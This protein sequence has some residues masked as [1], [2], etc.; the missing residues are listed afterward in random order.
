[1]KKTLLTIW[2]LG[3]IVLFTFFIVLSSNMVAQDMVEDGNMEKESSWEILDISALEGVEAS[4]ISFDY[5]GDVPTGGSGGCLSI[6]GSG[7]TRNFIYQ[8]VTLIPGHTYV[9]NGLVKDASPDSLTN[10]W[11]EL[12]L[13]D[14]EPNLDDD[15]EDWGVD[16]NDYLI[17]MHSWKSVEGVDYNS[18]YQVDGTFL[19]LL[20]LENN[21]AVL[22]SP[23]DD[24]IVDNVEFTLPETAVSTWYVGIKMGCWNDIAESPEFE[25][26]FDN[27][28]LWDLAGGD[29]P[30]PVDYGEA[31]N[32][33]HSELTGQISVYPNPSNG[34][35]TI[36]SNSDKKISY[37]IYNSV[38]KL[39]KKG[40]IINSSTLDLTK[41]NKGIYLL[42]LS[43]E[44]ISQ[45]QKLV[46]N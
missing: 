16:E 19:E 8:E 3:T 20:P 27:I 35:I 5:T 39:V 14:E 4:D 7:I 32:I 30:S 6:S 24:N 43:N 45:T 1:M 41:F 21:N 17:Q 10:Y 12:W 13:A 42:N 46:V 26:L 25:Y 37:E 15:A 23:K 33:K 31:E 44:L 22:S 11:V 36:N 18:M 29:A 38:G 40:S 28:I 2:Q 9:L 34:F